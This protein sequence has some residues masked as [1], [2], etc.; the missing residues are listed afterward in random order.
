MTLLF[1]YAS[2][3][4]RE[5]MAERCP[6]AEPLGTG[7]LADH[8]L[9][10]R[11]GADLEPHAGATAVGVVWRLGPDDMIALDHYE[12]FPG[13]YRK[14]YRLVQLAGG[15]SVEAMLYRMNRE[16]YAVPPEEYLAIV[17]EGYQDFGLSEAVLDAAVELTARLKP[18]ISGLPRRP[19]FH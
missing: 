8:R 18:A 2:N 9:V 1:A 15:E 10:F 6:T 11:H 7:V 17:R 4:N 5:R 3:L 19:G 12:G 16:G 13:L 14:D